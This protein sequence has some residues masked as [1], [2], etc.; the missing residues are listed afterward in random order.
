MKVAGVVMEVP[1]PENSPQAAPVNTTLLGRLTRAAEG[2]RVCSALAVNDTE[3]KSIELEENSA[4]LFYVSR[5]ELLLHPAL[6]GR[7]GS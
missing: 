2:A 5:R 4:S 7:A 6:I 1:T 3:A